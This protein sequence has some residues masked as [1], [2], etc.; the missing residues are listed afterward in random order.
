MKTIYLNADFECSTVEKADTVQSVETDYFDGKC[1]AFIEGYRF[2][3]AGQRWTKKDGVV[4]E[5]E[6]VSPFKDYTYLE[7]VQSL[8]EEMLPQAEAT[9]A[10]AVYTAMMTDTLIEV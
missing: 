7:M 3:P 8:Y 1:D 2:V 5:G 6:M 9:E 10:Q 4:F